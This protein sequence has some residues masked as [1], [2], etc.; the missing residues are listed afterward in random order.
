M[1][2]AAMNQTVAFEDSTPLLGDAA[3]LRRRAAED[4]YLFFSGL[5][6]TVA[7]LQVRRQV[8]ELCRRH[9]W[10]SEH[11]PLMDGISSGL[12]RIMEGNDPRWIAFYKDVLKL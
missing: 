6:P 10:L 11:E 4:G 2:M 3:S 7:V 1:A 9:G 12:V 5:L 8:L